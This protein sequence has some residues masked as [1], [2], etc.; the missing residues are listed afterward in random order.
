MN[1]WSGQIDGTVCGWQVQKMK[2]K[3]GIC[4]IE[5][6]RILL[7]LELAKNPFLV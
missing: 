4:D 2:T 5:E 1:K 7:N 6:W 3:W